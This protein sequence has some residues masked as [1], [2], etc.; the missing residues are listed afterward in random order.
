MRRIFTGAVLLILLGV[1][2]LAG[3]IKYKGDI[4]VNESLLLPS[5]GA[6]PG[7]PAS[8]K[9]KLYFKEDGLFQLN[10]SGD[11]KPLTTRA[12]GQNFVINPEGLLGQ[13]GVSFTST[14]TP[15]NSNWNNFLDR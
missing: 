5:L 8:S 13:R 3:A 2:A 12:V 7:N 14:T 10:G 9:W 4:E 6:S 11:E 1:P 15:D